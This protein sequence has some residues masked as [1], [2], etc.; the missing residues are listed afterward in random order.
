[1]KFVVSVGGSD[2]SANEVEDILNTIV[3]ENEKVVIHWW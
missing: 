2:G 1:M 3:E